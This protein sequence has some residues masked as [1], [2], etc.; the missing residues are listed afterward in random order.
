[1]ACAPLNSATSAGTKW[2]FA[3]RSYTHDASRTPSTHPI[4]RDELRALRRL[5]RESEASPFV[6]VS[7]RGSPFTTAGFARMLGRAA[8]TA[9]FPVFWSVKIYRENPEN[10][11]DVSV[12]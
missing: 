6:F 1:M 5:Q 7:E 4:Q 3:A 8:A 9:H 12:G 10:V 2:T 11:S